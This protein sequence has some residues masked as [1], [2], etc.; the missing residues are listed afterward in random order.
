MNASSRLLP[1][2]VLAAALV[3][4]P[5]GEK[6]QESGEPNPIASAVPA[7][8]ASG[9]ELM[10]A[11]SHSA[12]AG[13]VGI[14]ADSAGRLIL[15]PPPDAGAAPPAPFRVD[16]TLEA[17]S[18][19][20][21][22]A[23]GVTLAARFVWHDVPKAGAD[24]DVVESVVKELSEKTTPRATIDLAAH[25]RMRFAIASVSFPL[26]LGAE[27]RSRIDR[28]GHL[29]VWP[30]ADA[31][32]VL[33]LGALRSLLGER[34]ADVSPLVASTPKDLGPGVLVGHPT[35]RSEL[36]G[37][38]GRLV[39][40]QAEVNSSGRGG[41][42]LCRFLLE[43][44]ALQPSAVCKKDLIPVRAEYFWERGGRLG[45]EV[46][47]IVK[48]SDLALGGLYV[49]PAGALP[50]PGELP[51]EPSGIFLNRE[52]L[53]RLRKVERRSTEPAG[54]DAPGEGF[55][56]VNHGHALRY[57][58]LDGVPVAW[59]RPGE[60]QYVIGPKANR[61]VVSWRDFLGEDTTKPE[62]SFLPARLSVGTR[63][64]AGK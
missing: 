11:P 57:V 60:Q 8:L 25:G 47:S 62:L 50:K 58:L 45:F 14:P 31:Y 10:V 63:P 20:T 9:A 21:K 2:A 15:T 6:P 3:G 18:L 46:D 5:R 43:L 1:L 34:R 16:E 28:L 12:V 22:E 35:R 64:D 44:D 56:A 32:R 53:S 4:C 42:L 48:R 55:H 54:P 61:Y 23:I 52:E 39:I 24:P 7:P 29:L 19:T 33:S 49:P 27:V 26:P 37:P 59:I 13:R 17:D 51:P 41:E 30:N 36:R 40:E 38:T